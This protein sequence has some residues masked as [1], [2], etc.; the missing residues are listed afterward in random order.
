LKKNDPNINVFNRQ[1]ARS[2]D[3]SGLRTFVEAVVR[4]LRV[5]GGVSV[6]LVSDRVMRRYNRDFAGEDRPTDVLSFPC[7]ATPEGD[8]DY[9]G[10]ILI[11]VETA[12][13]QKEG[14]LDQEVKVLALH[15]ILHLMGYDHAAD[16][17][18]MAALEAK[19]RRELALR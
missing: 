14:A 8:A 3:P 6:V 9:M 19:L 12:D 5:T 11:S 13:R 7:A 18:E 10:D 1:R 16:Q 4:R 17:G 15:G 2:L